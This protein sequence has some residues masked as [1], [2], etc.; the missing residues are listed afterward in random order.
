MVPLAIECDKKCRNLFS[1]IFFFHLHQPFKILLHS[2]PAYTFYILN[3]FSCLWRHENWG[4]NVHAMYYSMHQRHFLPTGFIVFCSS[5]LEELTN[6]SL[7]WQMSRILQNIFKL[8]NHLRL[9][10]WKIKI[11]LKLSAPGKRI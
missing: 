3:R 4:E 10:R 1:W 11:S 7:K 2:L 8:L 5:S 9:L 6:Q